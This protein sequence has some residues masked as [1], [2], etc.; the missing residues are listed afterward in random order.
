MKAILYTSNTGH[1]K[2]YAQLIGK[3]IDCEVYTLKEADK[4]L[5]HDDEIIYLG[6]L[7]ANRIQ[8]YPKA[9]KR[10]KIRAV[11]AVGL[12]DSGTALEEV[13]RENKIPKDTALFT[14]QGGMNKRALALPHRLAIQILIKSMESKKVKSSDEQRMIYLLKNDRNYVCEENLQSFYQWFFSERSGAVRM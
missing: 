1:T 12:C 9:S 13:I 10:Y 5:T 2:K 8:G 11:L 4:K 14:V 3:K 7:F 6:W